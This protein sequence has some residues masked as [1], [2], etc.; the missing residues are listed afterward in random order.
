MRQFRIVLCF[1]LAALLLNGCGNVNDVPSTTPP[2]AQ[3]GPLTILTS[4][5]LPAGTITVFYDI[6]LAASGGTPPY[7]WSLSPESPPLPD[8]LVLAASTGKISG[9]PTATGTTPTEFMVKDST[10]QS[11]QKVLSI[12]VNIAPTPLAILTNSLTPGTINQSYAFAFSPTGGT[13]PYS[14]ALKA[15]SPP[16]PNGLTLSNNGV[17]SG[18]PTVLSSATHTFTLRDATSLTVETTLQLS[19]N[20]IPLSITTNSPLPQGTVSQPYTL[21]LTGTGGTPPLAWS[22]DSGSLPA[23]LTLSTAGVISGTPTAVGTSNFTVQ[24]TDSTAPMPESE[25]KSLQ[26]IID[27]APLTLTP[28]T[29]TIITPAG[30]S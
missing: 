18:T 15:G 22:L 12:T 17:I 1:I 28:P 2:P 23:G 7:T 5:P 21:T 26:L 4:S 20:A 27:A 24:V 8:G 6:T 29:L 13:T 3:P 16:L 11:V 30:N 9:A 25:T 14:W 10:E 19:V